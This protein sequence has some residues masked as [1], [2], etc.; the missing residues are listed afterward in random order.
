MSENPIQT[1]PST[2]APSRSFG[3]RVVG[4]L[5]LDATVYDE[6]EHDP[7]S[8]GQAAG[9]IGLAAIAEGLGGI[10]QGGAGAL[11]GGIFS[12][13]L[14]WVLSCGIVW[15]IGV[16]GMN[17]TS[18]FPELL[19][20]LGFASAPKLLL[21][22]GVLPIGP[23]RGLLFLGV[24]VLT[25]VAFVIAVRQALDVTTGR[26]VLICVLAVGASIL[27]ALFLGGMLTSL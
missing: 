22:L 20:T 2:T 19:R 9:V 21:V 25:L 23:L 15:A 6:V 12:A 3:E 14:G 8:I 1:P 13:F 4:A 18:D 16:K 11:L 7:A 17:H 27:L 26:A 5:K 24:S 10:G